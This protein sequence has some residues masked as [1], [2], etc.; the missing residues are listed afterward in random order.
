MVG[1]YKRKGF[2]WKWPEPKRLI[3]RVEGRV[4]VQ[5]QAVEVPRLH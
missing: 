3:R 1:Y 2:A 5:K 4:T